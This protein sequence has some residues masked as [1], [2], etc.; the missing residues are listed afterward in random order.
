VQDDGS[1]NHSER[2][3][4]ASESPAATAVT[5]DATESGGEPREPS[6]ASPPSRQSRNV[7]LVGLDIGGFAMPINQALA[8]ARQIDAKG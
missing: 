1:G 7:K 3:R 8:I 2:P 6:Q 5:D 4:D